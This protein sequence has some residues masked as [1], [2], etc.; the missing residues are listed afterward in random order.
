MKKQIANIIFLV[1]MKGDKVFSRYQ[2]FDELNDWLRWEKDEYRFNGNFYSCLDLPVFGSLAGKSRYM[3]YEFHLAWIP[4][5]RQKLGRNKNGIVDQ[6]ILDGSIFAKHLVDWFYNKAVEFDLYACIAYGESSKWWKR[7][8][9]YASTEDKA[10]Q[11]YQKRNDIRG[12]G[13]DD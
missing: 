10:R 11:L 6:F 3:T 12:E 7:K 8:L 9:I 4:S 1:E 5:V 13:W 2:L